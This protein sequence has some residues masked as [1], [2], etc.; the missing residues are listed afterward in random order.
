MLQETLDFSVNIRNEKQDS[1]RQITIELKR[2]KRDEESIQIVQV[3]N[4][5]YNFMFLSIQFQ[6]NVEKIIIKGDR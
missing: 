2:N 4:D 5:N 1:H 3:R 6:S